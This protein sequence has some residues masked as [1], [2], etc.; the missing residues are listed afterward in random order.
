MLPFSLKYWHLG[1][2]TATPIVVSALQLIIGLANQPIRNRKV[3]GSGKR[4]GGTPSPTSASRNISEK[5]HG[6]LRDNQLSK[7]PIINQPIR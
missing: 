1:N 4:S 7:Y 6:I 2:S 5:Y 3:L